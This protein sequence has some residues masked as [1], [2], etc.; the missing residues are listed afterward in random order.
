MLPAEVQEEPALGAE[1]GAAD[2]ALE[3]PLPGVR[4]HVRLEACLG[5]LHLAAR[6]AHA[7]PPLTRRFPGLETAASRIYLLLQ[8]RHEGVARAVL[9]MAHEVALGAEHIAAV[10][11]LE[12]SLPGVGP[13]M[14]REGAAAFE[15]LATIFTDE[16]PL[17]RVCRHVP[18]EDALPLELSAALLALVVLTHMPLKVQFRREQP[19]ALFTMDGFLWLLVLGLA[20]TNGFRWGFH[21]G[22]SGERLRLIRFRGDR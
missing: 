15:R 2:G 19:I 18:L 9:A 13:A 1:V 22:L 7:L 11:A 10:L 12:R 3:G 6:L 14:V 8:Q 16:R 4:Q 5:V 17:L 20:F 21:C